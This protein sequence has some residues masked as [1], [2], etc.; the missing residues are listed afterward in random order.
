[1]NMTTIKIP[2]GTQIK[3]GDALTLAPIQ[4]QAQLLHNI[5]Y[6]VLTSLHPS[7]RRTFI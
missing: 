7:I 6:T 2:R 1:M 4:A 3:P 5:P